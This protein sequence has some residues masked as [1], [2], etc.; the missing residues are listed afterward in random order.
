MEEHLL[1]S[2]IEI[3]VYFA[4]ENDQLAE[5]VDNLDRDADGG[6]GNKVSAAESKSTIYSSL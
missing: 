1:T 2:E 6:A 5:L 4:H 3:P